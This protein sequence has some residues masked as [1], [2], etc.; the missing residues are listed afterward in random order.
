MRERK[1]EM[2]EKKDRGRQEGGKADEEK[3][4]S[5]VGGNGGGEKIKMEIGIYRRNSRE[6]VRRRGRRGK[7]E[8]QK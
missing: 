5:V 7:Q 2:E 8:K 1:V 4:K 6:G 3:R